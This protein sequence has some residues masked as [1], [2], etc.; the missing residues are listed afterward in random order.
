MG[1][2]HGSGVGEGVGVGGWGLG[3]GVAVGTGV[4]VEIGVLVGAGVFVGT[5]VSVGET[6]GVLV[7]TKVGVL[8]GAGVMV[9]RRVALGSGVAVFVAVAVGEGGKVTVSCKGVMVGRRVDVA[10]GSVTKPTSGSWVGTGVEGGFPHRVHT[11]APVPNV[12]TCRNRRRENVNQHLLSA[13][14]LSAKQCESKW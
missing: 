4:S 9:L 2:R 10:V 8:V 14:S 1:S 5:N 7:G 12:I 6:V 11:H 3:V 13:P